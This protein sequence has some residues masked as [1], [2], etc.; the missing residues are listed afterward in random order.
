MIRG[1][2][3]LLTLAWS[4]LFSLFV[5]KPHI[6]LL[7]FPLYLISLFAKVFFCRGKTHLV[8]KRVA[9][10]LSKL[11]PVFIKLGQSMS[12]KEYFIGKDFA[13]SLSSL[14]DSVEYKSNINILKLL[15]KAYNK[16]P[17]EIFHHIDR[18]P[19]SS[20][21]IAS[22][23]RA[24]LLYNPDK[25]VVIKVVKNKTRK[26]ITR[27]LSI[28]LTAVKLGEKLKILHPRLES[29]KVVKSL[30][31]I[32]E[33]EANLLMEH[34]NLKVIKRNLA[35]TCYFRV[36]YSYD[37]FARSNVLVL[38]Y[39]PDLK[40]SDFTQIQHLN[41]HKLA[42][43]IL[44]L[45]CRQVYQ[46]GVFHADLHPGNMFVNDR[47]V[48]TLIDCGNIS[49]LPE[50]DRLAVA[51]VI[52]AFLQKDYNMIVD[53]YIDAGY[54]QKNINEHDREELCNS[55][56]EIGSKFVGSREIMKQLHISTLLQQM[57]DLS[58]KFEIATQ[59]QLLMLQKTM[60]YIESIV[61]QIAPDLNVWEVIEPWMRSWV[62]RNIPIQ[63]R[64]LGQLVNLKSVQ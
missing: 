43:Q 21:S 57:L 63:N 2:R 53:C 8:H 13:K 50:K 9:K 60:L 42:K 54:I 61:S 29:V 40:M 15:E 23:F 37:Q 47:Y 62:K 22:V 30:K 48:I 49:I 3:I 7:I 59:E 5:L 10:S 16:D 36:A 52:Y 56:A 33:N 25:D 58:V 39:I 44:L 11:G 6:K 28:A 4:G 41:R 20:A 45:Y 18:V 51:M 1:I 46:D 31:I 27:D 24:N 12:L 26:K 38:D 32:F 64:L 34:E 19:I 35:D 55:F 17:Y 14:Q